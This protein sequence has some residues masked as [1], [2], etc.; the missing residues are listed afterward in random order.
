MATHSILSLA[1]STDELVLALAAGRDLVA[2]GHD[3][4]LHGVRGT[5]EAALAEG[6][7]H[8][9]VEAEDVAGLI[10]ALAEEAD[11][12]LVTDFLVVLNKLGAEKGA[13]E[14]IREQEKLIVLD[15]WNIGE[16]NRVLDLGSS[17]ATLPQ[18][19]L[20][21][22][23]RLVPS[24]MAPANAP[25]AFRAIPTKPE[26]DDAERRSRARRA[27]QIDDDERVLLVMT[28][29]VQVED[30]HDDKAMQHVLRR[31]V[32]LLGE[33]LSSIEKLHVLHVGPGPFPWKKGVGRYTWLVTPST[34]HLH[35]RFAAAD[36][37]L[38]LDAASWSIGW[39]MAWRKPVMTVIN[40]TAVKKADQRLDTNFELT[41]AMK[42][43]LA[44]SVPLPKMRVCPLG[45]Y[46]TLEPAVVDLPYR[47]LELLDEASFVD[48]CR[49]LLFDETE[50]A[51][52]IEDL[53]TFANERTELPTAAELWAKIAAE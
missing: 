31:V 22:K 42:K 25:G 52:S 33:R 4:W 18:T 45:L 20:L 40:S 15:P 17:N 30:A 3:V 12:V 27:L 2:K 16:G 10:D 32:R 37:V 24:P 26:G 11:S 7:P 48:T 47:P 43:W 9:G 51:R 8:H 39:S 19:T 29:A 41:G 13:L 28:N 5:G 34:R 53:D 36:A 38:L 21:T 6:I 49:A 1:Q 35:N 14:K 50:R 44:E 23:K 46:Q